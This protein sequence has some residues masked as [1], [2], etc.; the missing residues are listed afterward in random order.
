MR[1]WT[2]TN[3]QPAPTLGRT[4][5]LPLARALAA[6][7]VLAV[8]AFPPLAAA[9]PMQEGPGQEGPA[10]SPPATAKPTLE[11]R[12]VEAEVA[13]LGSGDLAAATAGYDALLGEPGLG[14]DLRARAL[15]G[16]ARCH[17]KRGQLASA[18]ERLAET[19]ALAGAPEREQRQSR[20]LLHELETGEPTARG[21]D[22]IGEL[23][24]NPEIQA[25]VFD[26]GMALVISPEDRTR[27]LRQLVALGAI[28]APVLEK[29][30]DTTRD[31]EHRALIAGVLVQVGRVQHLGA[32]LVLPVA[33]RDAMR[34]EI[35]RMAVA[36]SL[37]PVSVR[38]RALASLASL[39]ATAV[40]PRQR[41]FLRLWL[42]GV[43]HLGQDLATVARASPEG[44]TFRELAQHVAR[45]PGGSLA[46]RDALLDPGSTNLRLPALQ[47]L[48]EQAP[49]VLDEETCVAVQEV[50]LSSGDFVVLMELHD[51][52]VA[53]EAFDILVRLAPPRVLGPA[54]LGSRDLPPGR[55]SPVLVALRRPLDDADTLRQLA[56]GW[57]KVLRAAQA[58]D[59]LQALAWFQPEAVRDY[60]EWLLEDHAAVE[61]SHT[62]GIFGPDSN[63]R[64]NQPCD[65]YVHE[66]G[67]LVL[68]DCMR[69]HDAA[70]EA[71]AFTVEPLR[72]D[73][74]E[75]LAQAWAGL[76][77]V[78]GRRGSSLPASVADLLAR[79][80]SRR[81]FD[82]LV[83]LAAAMRE[84]PQGLERYFD[85]GQS[86]RARAPS[87]R[88]WLPEQAAGWAQVLRVL[89]D[90]GRL[91]GLAERHPSAVPVLVETIQG[92]DPLVP[93]PAFLGPQP[94]PEYVDQILALV[95]RDRPG[96]LH[97]ARKALGHWIQYHNS[98]ADPGWP[99]GLQGVDAILARVI[100]VIVDPPQRVPVPDIGQ[101]GS[102]PPGP[103][104][105]GET[106]WQPGE[107]F[108]AEL[109]SVLSLRGIRD[110]PLRGRIGQAL[111]TILQRHPEHAGQDR[112]GRPELD[113]VH[114]A[115]IE[116]LQRLDDPDLLKAVIQDRRLPAAVRAAA[117]LPTTMDALPW[118]TLA[119]GEDPIFAELRFDSRTHDWLRALPPERFLQILA[120]G[121][122]SP[123]P[124]LRYQFLH[125]SLIRPLDPATALPLLAGLQ[126][127]PN[128]A[129]R[130][131]L[132][133]H[134]GRMPQPEAEEILCALLEDP[135]PEVRLQAAR[136]LRD[137]ATSARAIPGLTRLLEDRD[138]KARE[139]ALEALER[140]RNL[141]EQ[142]GEWQRVR[143]ALERLPPAEREGLFGPGIERDGSERPGAGQD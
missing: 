92:L 64:R 43:D 127:D 104:T 107:E 126:T 101:S 1:P 69:C 68:E 120:D 86:P 13:E 50:A 84:A 85:V 37:Q 80:E 119:S 70:L 95:H 40:E 31:P 6:L 140:L 89:G 36:L 28:A 103:Q 44:F 34:L 115:A 118:S 88:S 10:S 79:L 110:H 123:H 24:A 4:Q 45:L 11:A 49:E 54:I 116:G 129:V 131:L 109:A 134:L 12:L 122:R 132:A 114:A 46:L 138:P 74:V 78:T 29:L 112:L 143:A 48:A 124:E 121:L 136:V 9:A 99:A 108:A 105:P 65:L 8:L 102:R 39:E 142:R 139:V 47:A 32:A 51:H 130:L 81:D 16:L 41:A 59:A 53:R 21:F 62:I 60:R 63:Y 96:V 87:S 20:S 57:A 141:L 98:G 3:Q 22:W 125:N 55:W 72:Q 133:L 111:L 15:L 38:E 77:P 25:R 91:N 56:P 66:I 128:A 52:L 113:R 5:G 26:L 14:D 75:R 27:A 117:V 90:L 67:L 71:L 94:C 76:E 17:R 93:V 7:G 135:A 83:R 137:G 42:G 2:S 100:E 106:A 19:L 30:L 33:G 18:R 61:V 35:E 58:P 82:S 97:M 73:V 23:G